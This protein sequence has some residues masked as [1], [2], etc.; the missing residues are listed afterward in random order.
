MATANSNRS[1][2]SDKRIIGGIKYTASDEERLKKAVRN[3]NQ[4]LRRELKRDASKAAFLPEKK[5]LKVERIKVQ[6]GTRKEFKQVEKWLTKIT[7][8]KALERVETLSGIKTTK[9]EVDKAKETIRRLN[10]HIANERKKTSIDPLK[11]L[12]DPEI[13]QKLKKKKLGMETK[14]P[15]EFK[16]FVAHAEKMLSSAYQNEGFEKY[17]ENYIKALKSVGIENDELMG[18]INKMNA[19]ELYRFTMESPDTKIDFVYDPQKLEDI[20][21]RILERFA[22]RFD[23]LDSDY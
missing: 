17:K 13:M 19:K 15:E 8:P 12:A 22:E 16:K 18:L 3:Y 14:S 23:G 10:L 21:E 6:A 4:Q 11:G 9:Y 1:N 2:S 7:E 20:E 5:S